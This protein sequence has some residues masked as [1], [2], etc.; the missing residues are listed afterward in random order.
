MG[1]IY[2]ET[3]CMIIIKTIVTIK[4]LSYRLPR[5]LSVIGVRRLIEPH[6]I[7]LQMTDCTDYVVCVKSHMLHTLPSMV[8]KKHIHL[9]CT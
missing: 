6:S 7:A 2:F 1:A 8:V 3:P 9:V 5:Y 4:V